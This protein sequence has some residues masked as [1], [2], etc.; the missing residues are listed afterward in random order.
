MNRTKQPEELKT[1]QNKTPKKKKK[2]KKKNRNETGH[3]TGQE[4]EGI[5]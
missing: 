3:C 2:K 1:K 4:K 5:S